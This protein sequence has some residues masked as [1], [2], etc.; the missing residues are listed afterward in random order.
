MEEFTGVKA[1]SPDTSLSAREREVLLGISRGRS[2]KR[3]SE[4]LRLSAHTIHTHIKNIYRKLQVNSRT[5]ALISARRRGI[6]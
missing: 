6:V 5:E 2:E 4:E 1:S 3:L